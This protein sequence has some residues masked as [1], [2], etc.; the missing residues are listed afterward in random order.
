MHPERG[1]DTLC[2]VH[3]TGVGKCVY[4]TTKVTCMFE[5]DRVSRMTIKELFELASKHG[6]MYLDTTPEISGLVTGNA[7]W[8]KL[9]KPIYIE[10]RDGFL[11]ISKL[12]KQFVFYE[13]IIEV[14]LHNGMRIAGT[15][16]HKLFIR[17]LNDYIPLK[18]ICKMYK[19][20]LMTCLTT[21]G[22]SYITM[23][24]RDVYTGSVYD[25]EVSDNTHC[26]FANG[27]LTHNTCSSVLISKNYRRDIIN[28]NKQGIHSRIYIV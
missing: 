8:L 27:I 2:L 5:D 20:T 1:N 18:H 16:N 28:F 21:S 7:F 26:Y 22:W 19:F 24:N 4:P 15:S 13:E 6:R 12:Y 17:E 3:T 11:P 14:G 23:V 10:S 9:D 25:V